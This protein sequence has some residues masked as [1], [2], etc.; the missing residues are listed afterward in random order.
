MRRMQLWHLVLVPV[1][2]IWIYPFVWM[3]STAVKSQREIFLGGVSVIPKKWSFG[4]FSRA[5]DTAHF[6]AYLS[7]TVVFSV[8]TVVVVVLVS[9][10]AGYALGRGNLP[11]KKIIVG[12][13]IATMFI[14]Q[15]YT[16]IPI[17]KLVDALHLQSGL[18]GAVLATAGPAHVVPIL[19][20]MGYFAGMPQELED[21]AL[22]DGAGY[23]RT[24][25]RIMLPLA[26]PVI[27]TVSLFTFMSAW[28][29]F[30]IP[31][32]F[33][34][35]RPDLRTL[36]VGMY[37]FFGQ[38]STDWGG[39]AAAAVISL[40]PIIAIFVLLQRTFV[41]GIAGSVKS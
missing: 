4:N 32:V 2:L 16:I 11:G 1:C 6:G 24:F 10:T 25:F 5:W 18:L 33:T 20:F 38:D 35:G 37:S 31:L 39:L 23:P 28:N 14:P 36:G 29:S 19:L 12:L 8:T 7:N 40:L 22:I 3:A 9:A 26:K 13:L 21:A 34:L 17:L 41:E 27:S 15:G 30:F